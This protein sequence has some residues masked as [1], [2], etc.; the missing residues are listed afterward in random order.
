M[1]NRR[2]AK[3][4]DKLSEGEQK[5]RSWQSQQSRS[6]GEDL[7]ERRWVTGP[8]LRR[9]LNISPP[10]LWR[11]RHAGGFPIA[12]LIN[13]RLYFALDEVEAWMAAQPN[14]A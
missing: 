5:P 14:A 1:R 13:G 7:R 6:S 4:R 9:M 10:T 12:K 3:A 11:W 8:A 2:S